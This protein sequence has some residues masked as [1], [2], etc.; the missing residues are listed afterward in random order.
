MKKQVHPPLI[1]T[2]KMKIW[3]DLLKKLAY[4]SNN[5]IKLKDINKYKAALA[6]V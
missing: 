1:E 5:K 2:K 3:L 4:S 6:E